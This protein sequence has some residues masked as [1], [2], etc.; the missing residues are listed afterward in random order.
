MPREGDCTCL[1]RDCW[2]GGHCLGDRC[3]VDWD[4]DPESFV[5]W[6]IE[7]ERRQAAGDYP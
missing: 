1:C 6:W 5:F 4:I 7:A 2:Q 3:G